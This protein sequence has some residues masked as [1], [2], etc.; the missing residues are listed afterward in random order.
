MLHFIVN[1]NS[2]SGKGVHIWEAAELYLK[3]QNIEYQMHATEYQGHATELAREICELPEEDIRLVAVGGDGTINEVVNGMTNFDKVHFGVVPTGSGNDFARGLGLKG[4]PTEHLERI[5]SS[6][7]D[8]VIDLGQVT[9]DGCEK[10]RKFAISAGVGM[11]A[12]VCERVE[13]SKLKKILNKIGLGKLTYVLIT[14]HTLFSMATA[15]LNAKVDGKQKRFNKMI[16]AAAMNFRAEGGGVPMSPKADAQD[17]LFSVCYCYGIPKPLTFVLLLFLIAA[18]H[19]WIKGIKIIDSKVSDMR[20]DIPM[21]LHTDG[22]VVGH[23]KNAKFECISGIL[24][25]MI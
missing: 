25:M 1:K 10:P 2:R 21:T 13:A 9:W 12:I 18:K 5:L 22:E 7:E 11:D 17:G 6:K 24:H 14:I 8:F 4:T 23:V 20:L 19:S 15:T 16:F 3:A